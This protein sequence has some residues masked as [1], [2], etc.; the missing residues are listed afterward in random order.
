MPKERLHWRRKVRS[1]QCSQMATDTLPWLVE[2]YRRFV[3]NSNDIRERYKLA[4][5]KC[6]AALTDQCLPLRAETDAVCLFE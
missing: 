6:I 4:V 5:D 2:N 1:R 3:R